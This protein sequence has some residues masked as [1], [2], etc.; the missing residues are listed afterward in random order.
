MVPNIKASATPTLD[1]PPEKPPKKEKDEE[2]EPKKKLHPFVEGLLMKLPDP[3]TD[4][5]M[6]GRKKWLQA[7]VQVFEL[8]YEDKEGTGSLKIEKDSAK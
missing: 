4:W 8:M 2:D 5:P 7:A 6:D 1:T 3:D